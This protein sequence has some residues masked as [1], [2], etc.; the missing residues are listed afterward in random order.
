[1][2]ESTDTVNIINETNYNNK[3]MNYFNTQLRIDKDIIC[4]SNKKAQQLKD[5]YTS[6]QQTNQLPTPKPISRKNHKDPKENL[7]EFFGDEIEFK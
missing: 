3:L 4:I 2:C 6:L 7:I 5:L 1:M